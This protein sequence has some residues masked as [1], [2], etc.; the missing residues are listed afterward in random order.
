MSAGFEKEQEA[1]RSEIETLQAE[2]DAHKE[3]SQRA[4][5]FISLVHRYT[6][7]EELTTTIL[8]E[9][10]EKVIVHEAVWSEATEENRRMG[11]RSQSVDIFLKYI[12]N[13]AAPDLRSAEEIE[14]ERIEEEKLE[15][16]RKKQR[17]YARR[18]A[19][20]RKAAEAKPE[21]KTAAAVPKPAA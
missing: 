3:D 19:A 10:V 8:N 9:F 7:F 15:K 5:N 16:R 2:V 18:K 6:R 12:G 14:A 20:E 21:K 13:Y 11:T 1:L 17:E 4:D